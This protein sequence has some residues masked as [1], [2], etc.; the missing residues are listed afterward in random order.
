[1]LLAVCGPQTVEA[2]SSGGRT[3]EVYAVDLTFQ[4]QLPVLRWM[5]ARV[6]LAFLR[7]LLT[8]SLYCNLLSMVKTRYL[9]DDTIFSGLPWIVYSAVM[10][11]FLLSP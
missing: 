5:N 4:G 2:Y 11:F 9:A 3:K 1:M 8:C 6:E 7:M 10:I